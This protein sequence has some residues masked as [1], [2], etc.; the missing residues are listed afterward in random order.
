MRGICVAFLQLQRVVAVAARCRSSNALSQSISSGIVVAMASERHGF[1]K[2]A[3]H[4]RAVRCY[5]SI[6]PLLRRFVI[7][8]LI[9]SRVR[10]SLYWLTRSRCKGRRLPQRARRGNVPSSFCGFARFSILVYHWAI[11]GTRMH[12]VLTMVELVRFLLVHCFSITI[13]YHYQ[14][15]V[16]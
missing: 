2:G 8:V 11:V 5:G 14:E 7:S 15:E 13:K 6:L 9:W 4:G 16:L 3:H 12:R 1:R 10:L